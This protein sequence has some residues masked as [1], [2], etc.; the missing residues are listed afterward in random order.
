MFE[1]IISSVKTGRVQRKQF[2][3]RDAADAHVRRHED[4]LTMA[5][6]PRSLGDFRVEVRHVPLAVPTVHPPLL[7]AA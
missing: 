1:V 6:R 4:K 7:I 3:T 5:Q 2:A